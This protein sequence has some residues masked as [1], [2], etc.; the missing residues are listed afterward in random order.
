MFDVPA[1]GFAASFSISVHIRIQIKLFCITKIKCT[2]IIS[3]KLLI[4]IF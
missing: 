1:S 2:F 4:T 3:E